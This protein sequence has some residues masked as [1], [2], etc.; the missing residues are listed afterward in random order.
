MKSKENSRI[1]YIDQR[2]MV[3]F[4]N[5]QEEKRKGFR[6]NKLAKVVNKP[7]NNLTQQQVA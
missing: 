2:H 5:V 6:K 7:Q 3:N 1:L 4:A